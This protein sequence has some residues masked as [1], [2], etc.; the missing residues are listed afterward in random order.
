MQS[1]QGSVVGYDDTICQESW[2]PMVV[3][4]CVQTNLPQGSF[5]LGQWTSNRDVFMESL[6]FN[7]IQVGSINC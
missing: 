6:I 7:A 4:V 2:D 1:S 3:V 5:E